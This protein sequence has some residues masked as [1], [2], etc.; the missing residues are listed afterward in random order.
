MLEK[1]LGT[2]CAFRLTCW[3]RQAASLACALADVWDRFILVRSEAFPLIAKV[4]TRIHFP[5]SSVIR[6]I[7]STHS[8]RRPAMQGMTAHNNRL[9]LAAR[10][11]SVAAWSQST[12]AAA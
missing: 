8:T 9:K 3:T 2:M 6:L 7:L 5:H 12:R 1:T 11:R 4:P 10:G